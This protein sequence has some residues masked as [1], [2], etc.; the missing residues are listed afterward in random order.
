MATCSNW[1]SDQCSNEWN[2]SPGP[3]D[4][5]KIDAANNVGPRLV[6][7]KAQPSGPGLLIDDELE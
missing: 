3:F 5:Q 6:I 2:L 7:R 4:T 1:W